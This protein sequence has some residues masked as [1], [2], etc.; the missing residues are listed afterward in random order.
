MGTCLNTAHVADSG[1]QAYLGLH[2]T[3][4]SFQLEK[5]S[6]RIQMLTQH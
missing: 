2:R 4:K 1:L 5:P 6:N 3:P